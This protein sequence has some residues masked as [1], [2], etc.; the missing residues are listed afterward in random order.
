MADKGVSAV[1]ILV[2]TILQYVVIALL[3]W[4]RHPTASDLNAEI[5]LFLFL[6]QY[7]NTAILIL[8]VN[9]NI[10]EH[11][12]NNHFITKYFTHGKYS[13]YTPEWYQDVGAKIISTMMIQCCLP[14]GKNVFKM[15]LLNA[16]R[17]YD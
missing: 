8:L 1:I 7:L 17:F 10:G 12:P 4:V 11:A 16:K 15:I 9:C 5:T 2:N 3:E 6:S 13:D 14:V